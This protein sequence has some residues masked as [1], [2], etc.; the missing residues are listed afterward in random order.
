MG[1]K[2]PESVCL[3]QNVGSEKMFYAKALAIDPVINLVCL[4]GSGRAADCK[5][6]HFIGM[7]LS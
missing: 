7:A 4:L 6:G 2:S 3:Y 5:S 1:D